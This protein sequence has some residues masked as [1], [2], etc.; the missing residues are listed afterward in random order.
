MTNG[1]NIF[2]LNVSVLNLVTRLNIHYLVNLRTV[3]AKHLAQ[4]VMTVF[5]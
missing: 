3:I 5:N 2:G 1:H 4:E